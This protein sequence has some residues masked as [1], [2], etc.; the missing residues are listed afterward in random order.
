MG[1]GRPRNGSLFYD[2]RLK[3]A[4]GLNFGCVCCDYPQENSLPEKEKVSLRKKTGFRAYSGSYE[5]WVG[6]SGLFI[7]SIEFYE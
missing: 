6:I 4:Y 1:I 3:L 7:S 5:S 2:T